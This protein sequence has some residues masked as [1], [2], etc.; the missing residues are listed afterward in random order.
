MSMGHKRYGSF[1][2]T[3]IFQSSP[4]NIKLLAASGDAQSMITYIHPLGE[5]F[6]EVFAFLDISSKSDRKVTNTGLVH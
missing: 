6:I 3:S 5:G 2:L 1:Q 4:N